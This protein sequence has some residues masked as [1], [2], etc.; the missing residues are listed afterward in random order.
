MNEKVKAHSYLACVMT[1]ISRS[2]IDDDTWMENE[3]ANVLTY[4]R[5]SCPES[6]RADARRGARAT[7]KIMHA[8]PDV[9]GLCAL[10]HQA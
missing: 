6:S 4:G 5:W 8:A 1:K 10:Y 7:S 2:Q 3:K 9:R